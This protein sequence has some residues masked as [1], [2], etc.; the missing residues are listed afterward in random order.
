MISKPERL[1]T[2]RKN[3]LELFRLHRAAI[4]FEFLILVSVSPIIPT[5]ICQV[6]GSDRKKVRLD[7]KPVAVGC[8]ILR[9]IWN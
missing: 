1:P 9:D 2:R 3:I 4:N 6:K 8:E 5:K 7:R